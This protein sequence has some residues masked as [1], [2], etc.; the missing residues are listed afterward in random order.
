M[1]GGC[2]LNVDSRQERG[3]SPFHG[4]GEPGAFIGPFPAGMQSIDPVLHIL[5][6][7]HPGGILQKIWPVVVS[8]GEPCHFSDAIPNAPE[9]YAI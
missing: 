8:V 7:K 2:A 5:I 3:E 9:P 4:D 6:T 1:L